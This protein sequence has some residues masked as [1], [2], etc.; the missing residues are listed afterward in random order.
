MK[1]INS[2]GSSELARYSSDTIATTS[3]GTELVTT[4][5]MVAVAAGGAKLREQEEEKVVEMNKVR[6]FVDRRRKR[7]NRLVERNLGLWGDSMGYFL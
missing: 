2:G 5:A 6:R 7:K 1:A 4:G 3:S